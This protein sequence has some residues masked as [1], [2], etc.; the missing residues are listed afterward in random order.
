MK[1]AVYDRPY[2]VRGITYYRL[3]SVEKFYQKGIASWYGKEE[4]G[5]LTANGERYDM[6]ALTAAHKELPLGSIVRV[7]CLKTGKSIT[8]RINDRGPHV[9]GR[10]I[11]MSYT[12]A[13]RLGIVNLGLTEVE[14]T[15]LNGSSSDKKDGHFAVQVASYSN[16]DSAVRL[17]HEI[18]GAK[19]VSV[20][21]NGVTYYRVKI[22]GFATR[23]EAE[24]YKT[25]ARKRFSGAL[26]TSE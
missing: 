25:R 16:R 11:D 23:A 18:A 17:A 26:V 6:Y 19:V 9:P 2:T 1:G 12:G 24:R 20:V 14:L 13:Q 8:V 7:R 3:K 10:V 15:L 4:H 21:V 5:K 22:F